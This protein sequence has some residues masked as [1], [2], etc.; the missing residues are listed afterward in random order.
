MKDY[1][2]YF[3]EEGIKQYLSEHLDVKVLY[4]NFNCFDPNEICITLQDNRGVYGYIKKYDNISTLT[5]EQLTKDII[6]YNK[7]E[8]Y[9]I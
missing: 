5:L 8:G 9:G 2:D 1:I 3:T 7:K 6:E 4:I